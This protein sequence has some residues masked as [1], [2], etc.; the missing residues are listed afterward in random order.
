[1]EQKPYIGGQ[2][3]IEGVMMRAPCGLSVA[4][5]RPD[6]SLALQEQ[7]FQSRFDTGIWKKPFFRGVATLVESL[8]IGY[9]ALSFSAEQQMTEEE[10]EEM[11]GSG[12]GAMVVATLFAL[13]LFVALPQLLASGTGKLLGIDFGLT[14]ADFQFVIGGFK[15]LVVF[16]YLTAI[17]L[18]PD[19]RRTFQYHGAEHKTIHAWEA[20][21]PLTVAN[22]RAQ[23]TLHPRCGTTFLIVV[24]MVSIILGAIFAPLLLPG[25]EGALGW[26]GLL[27]LRIALLPVIAALSFEL[28]RFTAKYCTRGPLRV[29]LWPGFLFQKITTREPDDEQIEVAITAM[30]AAAWRETD[31]K[32]AEHSADP[33]L[34][35]NFEGFVA[36]LPALR[37]A[38][39][40][41][42]AS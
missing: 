37:P 13:G 9:R 40:H 20:E 16:L 28:Q 1:M 34:F 5:R 22:V 12:K 10:K 2:A 8:R 30:Q 42:A 18:M 38:A 33:L 11:A 4:V 15:I 27:L 21:L 36:A 39:R 26:V 25:A 19:V 35:P 41:E 14:D 7:P 6:G 32:D 17:S 24:V 31:G 29:F 3:V 23:S